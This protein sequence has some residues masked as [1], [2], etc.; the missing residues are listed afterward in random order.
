MEQGSIAP[1]EAYHGLINRR[2]AMGVKAHGLAND[3][4]RLGAAAI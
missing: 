3:I 2:I 4:G 1:A